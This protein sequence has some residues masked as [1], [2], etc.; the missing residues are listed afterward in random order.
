[1]AKKRQSVEKRDAPAEGAGNFSPV[2]LELL[3][4]VVDRRKAAFY[5]DLIQSF[6]VNMQITVAAQGTAEAT[7]LEYLGLG[8]SDRSAIFSVV[9]ADMLDT[10]YEVLEEKFR[11]IKGGKGISVALP[12]S[13]VIGKL[14]FGFLSNDKRTV[15][16]DERT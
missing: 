15:K 5:A 14:I 3:I 7:V 13:S 12:L 11:S 9:R 4:T 1:M 8:D 6:D 16:E 2:R 10:L